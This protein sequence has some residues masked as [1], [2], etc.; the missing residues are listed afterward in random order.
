MSPL[1]LLPYVTRM[2]KLAGLIIAYCLL[3]VLLMRPVRFAPVSPSA[4]FLPFAER[5]H[6]YRPPS[7]IATAVS[8][9]STAT[10]VDE[11][12]SKV[13]S[14]SISPSVVSGDK[15]KCFDAKR[16]SPSI[17]A[18]LLINNSLIDDVR[19]EWIKRRP[20]YKNNRKFG[21][22]GVLSYPIG[23]LLRMK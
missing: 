1:L 15:R 9:E 8:K 17:I 10:A 22:L 6:I 18:A 3:C 5:L 7:L 4:P 19:T 11:D 2:P 21:A 12:V 13:Q 23:K 16:F 14:H 20:R